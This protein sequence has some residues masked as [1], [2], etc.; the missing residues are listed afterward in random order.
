MTEGFGGFQLRRIVIREADGTHLAFA[1]EVEQRLPVAF[2][3]RVVLGRPMHLIEI[4]AL[5]AAPLERV[6][7]LAPNARLPAYERQRARFVPHEPALRE[8][9]GPVRER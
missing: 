1:L 5:D 7:E 8:H 6:L 3:R 4:D 2:E 9:V